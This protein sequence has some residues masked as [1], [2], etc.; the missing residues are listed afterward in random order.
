MGFKMMNCQRC[1]R[2]I[3]RESPGQKYCSSCA[4]DAKR[5]ALLKA[6]QKYRTLHPDKRH[7]SYAEWARRNPDKVR[8]HN[9]KWNEQDKINGWQY[10]RMWRERNP[11]K[12]K[13]IN[14]RYRLA[15]QDQRRNGYRQWMRKNI[16]KVKERW[17]N[18]TIRRR[19]LKRNTDGVHTYEQ[20]LDV[21]ESFGWRC[22]YCGCELNPNTV[23]EDHV[24]PL[25]RGGSNDISNIV[26]ACKFCNSS[27]GNKTAEEFTGRWPVPGGGELCALASSG[28][29]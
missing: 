6:N 17:K 15:H 14:R 11:E 29:G 2:E 4:K 28:T 24:I 21:C 25:S 3:Q 18:N 22:A 7:A 23:T 12:V 20:F 19:A 16:D 26:P 9:A 8:A 5:E 1:G 27:K 10:S 13:E